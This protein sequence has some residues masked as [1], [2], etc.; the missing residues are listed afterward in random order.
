MIARRWVLYLFVVAMPLAGITLARLFSRF[1]DLL[2]TPFTSNVLLRSV[3]G[4]VITLAIACGGF[5]AGLHLL[6]MTEAVLSFMGLAG[7]VTLAVGFAFR[8]IA[9]NFI[10]S[11]MLGVR[12]P[13]G[14][15]DYLEI[16]GKSGVV[17]SVNTR[18]TILV[19]MDGS[20]IRIPNAII[21]KEILVNRTASTAMRASFDVLIP[22]DAS[23][24]TATE[25]ITTALRTHEGFEPS[26]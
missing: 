19:G 6:G 17:K 13:F 16:A 7:V 23:I 1:S 2:L 25:A 11:V 24:A 4:S 22:W 20:H 26:P 3:L 8:D 14:V 12:R 5:L 21:F 10:A 18:A 9:E 15:G